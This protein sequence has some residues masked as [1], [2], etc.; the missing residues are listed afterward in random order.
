MEMKT[1]HHISKDAKAQLLAIPVSATETQCFLIRNGQ[2]SIKADCNPWF[3]AQS[4]MILGAIGRASSFEIDAPLVLCPGVMHFGHFIGDMLG[5]IISANRDEVLSRHGAKIVLVNPPHEIVRLLAFLGLRERCIALDTK[6]PIL[7]GAG[8]GHAAFCLKYNKGA[9]ASID[10]S[11]AIASTFVRSKLN[12]MARSREYMHEDNHSRKLLFVSGRS[13]RIKNIQELCDH[14]IRQGWKIVTPGGVNIISLMLEL[15][16]ADSLVC[17]NGSLLFNCFLGRE[18]PYRVLASRRIS[19][20]RQDWHDGG[21]VYN[22]FHRGLISYQICNLV[23]P[24][25]KH[26]YSDQIYV[27]PDMLSS[28]HF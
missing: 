9:A 17:E 16:R 18:A 6:E 7:I 13:E 1:L 3:Y 21:Y 4:Q 22:S 5:L 25:S 14:A 12:S 28:C 10:T 11:L 20:F 23:V 27:S 26:P 24:S 2:P 15:R 8:R 19:Q